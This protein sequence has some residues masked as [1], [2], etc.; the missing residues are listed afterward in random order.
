MTTLVDIIT[1][2]LTHYH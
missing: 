2:Y 1:Q